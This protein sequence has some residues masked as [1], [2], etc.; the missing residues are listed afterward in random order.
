MRIVSAF[1]PPSSLSNWGVDF[2]RNIL[3]GAG[4][5]V[6]LV[7]KSDVDGLVE[8]WRDVS[9]K[10]CLIYADLPDERVVEL[11]AR[12]RARAVVF[13]ETP[14]DLVSFLMRERG[15]ALRDAVATASLFFANFQQFLFRD[16]TLV[17]TRNSR[18][19]P[20]LIEAILDLFAAD[21]S[22]ETR[23]AARGRVLE[24]YGSRT[25]VDELV[26]KFG[27]LGEPSGAISA[28]LTSEEIEFVE[29]VLSGYVADTNGAQVDQICWPREVFLL[30]DDPGRHLSERI[31]LVGNARFLI[32]GPYLCL[33]PGEWIANIELEIGE[34]ASGNVLYVDTCGGAEPRLVRV[35]LP[36]SGRFGFTLP[37]LVSDARQPIE[38]RAV[39]GEGAIEGWIDW[40]NVRFSR[41]LG[42]N[43][44]EPAESLLEPQGRIDLPQSVR[45]ERTG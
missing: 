38:L 40:L 30:A 5:S 43:G 14:L 19:V 33:P 9:G 25:T 35:R 3:E 44:S 18:S 45:Q 20:E 26:A 6:V 8:A 28:R 12:T 11:Y 22:A 2:L 7:Y 36:S 21:L 34:N 41:V 17:V 16:R 1:G 42:A 29:R 23:D 32:Y 37:V 15:I 31:E 4:E 13:S 39:L 10:A 24:V 27:M